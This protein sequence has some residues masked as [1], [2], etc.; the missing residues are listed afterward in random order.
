MTQSSIFVNL[1]FDEDVSVILAEIL[2]S[3]GF[4]VLT[5]RDARNLGNSDEA[6]LQFST[7]QN[8]AILT[9]NR[10]DFER[11]HTQALQ[12]QRHHSGIFI[13]N[14]HPSDWELSK[15]MFKVLNTF[16]SDEVTNQ[17]FY[18]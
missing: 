11:L 7:A 15:R 12:D 14:R 17:L 8:R 3:H 16:T 2:S 1:Y 13:V 18:V 10:R 4:D 9:H 6:Q 5:T